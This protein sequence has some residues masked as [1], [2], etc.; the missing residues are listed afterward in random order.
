MGEPKNKHE[1]ILKTLSSRSISEPYV[2]FPDE[3]FSG[4]GSKRPPKP[5]P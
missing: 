2:F 4:R 1:S 5:Q 3:F